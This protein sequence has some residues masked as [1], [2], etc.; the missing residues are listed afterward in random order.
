MAKLVLLFATVLMA[1]ASSAAVL[2]LSTRGKAGAVI[3]LGADATDVERTAGSELAAGLKQ[4]TGAEFAVV[5]SDAGRSE[6]VRIFV[7]Q[8]ETVK[9]LMPD[10][11]W[12]SFKHDGIVIQ[13][14][15]K[16]LVLAGDRPRGSLYAVY[17][18]LEDNIGI[19]WWTPDASFV[20]AKPSLKV[21]VAR[22]IHVPPFRCR[23]TFYAKVINVNPVFATRMRLNG[24]HQPIPPEYGGHYTIP[25]F[26]HTFI[27][28][29]PPDKYFADHPEWYSEIDGK[30]VENGQLC[31]T[32]EDMRNELTRVA[33]EWIKANPSAGIISVSQNDTFY[34]CQCANCQAI[35]KEEGAES[36]PLLRFV[37]LVA[38]DIERQ[39]PEFL[40]DTLAY[41]YTRKAPAKVRPRDNVVVRL[42]SIE[43]DFARPLTASTNTA[44]MA[45]LESWK[46]IAGK[47]Y[48][49][50]YTVNYSNLLLPFPNLRV[51]APNIQLFAKS[52]VMSLF[53]QGDGYNQDANLVGLKTWL[54][55]RLMW[56]PTLDADKLTREFLNGYYG[57]A[58][59]YLYDYIQ[60]LCDAGE[61][62]PKDVGCFSDWSVFWTPEA[63]QEAV[64][65]MDKAVAAVKNDP[66]LRQRVEI[67]R[68]A[69]D[70]ALLAARS[71]QGLPVLGDG[72]S[73]L[74]RFISDSWRTGNQFR[75]ENSAMSDDYMAKLRDK[76]AINSK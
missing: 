20:P 49:W 9:K 67:Q 43:A 60:L 27:Q 11:D 41:Q 75:H 70:H 32:N 21:N 65:I 74:E 38:E 14:V 4:V 76:A 34:P 35:V 33:L 10:F 30:R 48:I 22:K 64:R 25:G 3:V 44:F 23:E 54:I 46:R 57:K 39:Y 19:R 26:V 47:L 55:S 69:I 2:D 12:R 68:L 45:D 71:K 18:F 53:E 51:L 17:T 61:K 6:P 40:V 7:G 13:P 58:G 15:A 8:T 72:N 29:L 1:T 50:D 28:M 59:R 16:G 24:H 63:L 56:D 66:V 5:D 31:L 42:C 36:G 37:N 73:L 52:N 62:S